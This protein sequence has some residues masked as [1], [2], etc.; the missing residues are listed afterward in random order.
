M[1]RVWSWSELPVVMDVDGGCGARSGRLVVERGDHRLERGER[2][3]GAAC[4]HRAGGGD[5]G[6]PRRVERRQVGGKGDAERTDEG[7]AGTGG[8]DDV[9]DRGRDATSR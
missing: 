5:D 1:E 9:D 6:E 3:L 4:G 8:V 2:A 7:V